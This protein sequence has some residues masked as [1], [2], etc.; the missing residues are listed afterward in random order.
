MSDLVPLVVA[1]LV[2]FFGLV[3]AGHGFASRHE[4]GMSTFAFAPLGVAGMVFA[5]LLHGF[6]PMPQTLTVS[7]A[8]LCAPL[9]FSGFVIEAWRD[10]RNAYRNALVGLSAVLVFAVW[11]AVDQVFSPLMLAPR[12]LLFARV[13]GFAAPCFVFLTHFAI[14]NLGTEA[15]RRYSKRMA[16]AIGGATAIASLISLPALARAPWNLGD[17]LLWVALSALACAW[18]QVAEGRVV[19]RLFA[20]RAVTWLVLFLGVVAV[21]AAAARQLEAGLDLPRILAGV[22]A[23]LFLGI[24]FVV[25]SEAVSRRVD[26]LLMPQLERDLDTARKTVRSMQDKWSHLE[27]LALA[28]ELSAMVAHEIKNPLQAVRGYAELMADF[29]AQLPE[30]ERGRFEKALTIIRDESDRINARVQSLLQLARPAALSHDVEAQLSLRQVAT[31]AVA[32]VEV[33]ARPVEISL[34]VEDALEVRGNPDG[35]RSAL[36]NLLRN[37]CDAQSTGTIRVQVSRLDGGR[38]RVLIADEGTGLSDEALAS[39]VVAFRSTRPDGTGLGL[40]IAQAGA[41]TCGGT[42]SFERN[43]PRGT[44]AII[45]LPLAEARK[46][47]NPNG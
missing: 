38:A 4:P 32:V 7:I 42:L 26:A 46:G 39:P 47:T 6:S 37:A 24:G 16:L 8:L 5:G 45:E 11:F 3:L 13:L 17:P 20:S 33:Q 30:S 9:S 21:L 18:V 31:E 29:T 14:R 23:T 36:V 10:T 28:G 25:V 1:L 40:I 35:L 43:T 27:R 22:V 44:K 34:D 19:V 15:E 12:P 2:A 41:A